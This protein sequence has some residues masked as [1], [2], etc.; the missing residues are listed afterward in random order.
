LAASTRQIKRRTQRKF[1]SKLEQKVSLMLPDYATYETTEL[2]YTK[3]HKYYP[4]FTITD[5]FY[6]EAKGYWDSEDRAKHLLIKE[7][8]PDK[9]VAFV[10]DNAKNKLN[11]RSK[12]T[13][14]DWCE[15]HGFMYCDVKNGIPKEW[16]E[17]HGNQQ[18]SKNTTRNRRVSRRANSRGV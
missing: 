12:I 5:V 18:S 4:D 17:Q 1:K 10:F 13:Y 6:I 2:G 15:K 16:M 14:A 7:Q 8:H 9:K 3:E 11:R